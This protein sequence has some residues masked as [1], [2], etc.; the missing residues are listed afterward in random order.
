MRTCGIHHPKGVL[1]QELCRFLVLFRNIVSYLCFSSPFCCFSCS[2][3]TVL[4]CIIS[5]TMHLCYAPI[6]YALCKFQDLRCFY[7]TDFLTQ[8][9]DV[10][11]KLSKHICKKLI[12]YFFIVPSITIVFAEIRYLVFFIVAWVFAKKFF[13]NTIEICNIGK[14]GK[15]SGFANIIFA[16][17]EK[18]GGFFYS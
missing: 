1:R 3:F 18:L 17:R 11:F 7:C 10:K 6:S 14:T 15:K 5:P 16:V 2:S 9:Q 13:K 8:C 12:F 4:W